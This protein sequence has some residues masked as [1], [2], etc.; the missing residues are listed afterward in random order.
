[1]K[2]SSILF[3]I[4]LAGPGCRDTDKAI[5]PADL[6]LIPRPVSSTLLKDSF[7]LTNK[8][9]I[10]I[11]ENPGTRNAATWLQAFLQKSTGYKNELQQSE[12][13]VPSIHLS[14]NKKADEEIKDEGYRLTVHADNIFINANK[15]AGL[16]YGIQTLLQLLPAAIEL[17]ATQQ[18]IQWK[19]PC[20]EI[21]DYPRFAWRGLMLD[22]S[23]HFF[24]VK[25][26]RQM[27]DEMAR[28]KFNRLHLHLTDD[29][30]WR[31]EIKSLPELTKTGAWRVGRT[32]WW[33]VR[34][35]PGEDEANTY[36]GFYTQD[37][38]RELV[39]YARSMS[40]EIIPEIDVPGHSLAAIASYRHLSCTKLGYK[41]NPGSKFYGTDDNALCAGNDSTYEFLKKVFTEVAALFPYEYIHVGGDECFKGFWKSCAVCKNIMKTAGLKDETELQGYF[42]KRL[43]K[44]VEA[45]GR[46]M[47]AWDEVLEGGNAVDATVM[48]WRNTEGTSAAIKKGRAVIVA[49]KDY[50]YLDYYQGDPHAEK[51]SFGMLRFKKVYEFEPVP[52]GTDDHFVLGGQ[53]NLWSEFVPEFSHAEYMLWPRSFALAETL[54]SAK[55]KRNWDD[56]TKRTAHHL[57]RL[58]NAGIN[59]SSSFYDAMVHVSKNE[60]G[61]IEI[62]LDTELDSAKIYYSFGETI[63]DQHSK[64]YKR[65]EKLLFPENAGFF[66]VVTYRDMQQLGKVLVLPLYELE[67]RIAEQKS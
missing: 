18:L 26:L 15:P 3:M 1:M 6:P 67:R 12:G 29:N 35:S 42:F 36:G 17:T 27:I 11:D 39:S 7:L 41:V 54:W 64:E 4:C 8:T 65:G 61:R 60:K 31:I 63:P 49:S 53:G 32:G 10:L 58:K 16:F 2:F 21:T 38:I 43:E 25:E 45:T 47:I 50:T 44:I 20:V 5:A 34:Q 19:I 23:R 37:E 28:Y 51:P 46:K 52:E 13:V 55:G 56:F 14:I 33:G 62:S 9:M 40:I 48:N 24:S 22:V 66:R 59:Y 30:G 57:Q